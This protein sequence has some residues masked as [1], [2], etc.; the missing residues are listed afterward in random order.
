MPLGIVPASR[1]RAH[2]VTVILSLED[3]AVG[4]I[5]VV[6]G[7]AITILI[8]LVAADIAGPWIDRAIFV[9]AVFVTAEAVAVPVSPRGIRQ[10]VHQLPELYRYRSANL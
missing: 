8:D 1:G 10:A 2:Q 9:V 6:I 4:T 3:A 7:A 5:G